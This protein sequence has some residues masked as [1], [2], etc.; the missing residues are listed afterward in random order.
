MPF[1]RDFAQ[2]CNT[3]FVSL[4][5]RLAPDALTRTARDFGLGRTARAARCRRAATRSSARRR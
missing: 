4:A 3:A 5:K 1:A 2:S